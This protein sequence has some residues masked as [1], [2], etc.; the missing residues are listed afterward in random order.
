MPNWIKNTIAIT[1]SVMIVLGVGAFLFY[2]L[3]SKSLPEYEGVKILGGLS[4]RVSIYT[5][6]YAIP[7]I[8]AETE[9]DAAYALGYLHARDRLFQMD[10]A[11]RAGEGRL[12]EIFGS[13][14]VIFDK[15]FKTVGID[16]TVSRDMDKINPLSRRM[17]EAYSN[18]VNAYIKESKGKLPIEFDALQYEPYPWK[19]EHSLIIGKL[20][21]WELNISWWTDVTFTHLVQKLGEDKVKEILPD[22]PENAPTII[23]SGIKAS[24]EVSTGF[25]ETDR[26][27]RNF[28]GFNGTHIGSNNWVVNGA[29]SAS[30][31]P[32]IA[33][34][35]HLAL[36]APGRW[37]AAVIR[38][39]DWKAEGVTL[40]GLPGIVIG[41]NE[42]ISWVLT[43]VMADDADFYIEHLD[44]SGKKYQFNN[45]WQNIKYSRYTIAVK[46]SEK[47][48]L[49]VKETHRG[50]II[51]DIHPYAAL[52]PDK[53]QKKAVL[54]MRWT[55]NEF[56]DELFAIL[57]INK[58]RNW[59]EFR[60]GVSHFYVPGQNFVYADKGGNIGYI[61]AARLPIRS[62]VNSTFI[63]DGATDL[64]DWKGYVPF[65]E[66]PMLYNPPENYIASANNKTVKN[67]NYHISNLWEPPSRITRITELLESKNRHS[68]N[69]FMRYQMDF[70]SPY[71][72]EM[73]PFIITAFNDVKVKDRTLDG[74]LNLLKVWDYDMGEYSQVPAI[75]EVFFQFLMR[76]TFEDE[77]GSGLYN[78]YVFVANVPYRSI[79]KMLKENN[80]TWFD[81]KNTKNIETRDDILRK[82]L[83]DAIRYFESYFG[84]NVQDWQWGKLHT[85]TFKHMFHGRFS[86][87][88]KYID[89]GPYGIG[90]SGTS[91]FN[92]EYSF[93]NPYET[94]LGPSMRF[95][96]D[97][98]KPE[99]FY[100]IL[101]TGQSGNV[102]SDHYKDMTEMWLTGKYLRVPTEE[103]TIKNS[104]YKLMIL[105]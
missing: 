72:R 30:G 95:L 62:S 53:I 70:I 71:V 13:R 81:D 39:G 88:D 102:L 85:V 8:Y 48:E 89:I 82:S 18:G 58:A 11:R 65:E 76:N 47:V 31:K 57:S 34:D 100:L 28:I 46:D 21:A 73:T 44:S 83:I 84:S 75:F 15:M 25:V 36:Q 20:L 101:T 50:P 77:M 24:P 29:R 5:D 4:S 3:L 41:K 35:P 61:C 80:S 97:F 10:I 54:S 92:T 78:E 104:G 22:F 99:A 38:G 6:T 63:C 74:I 90:G 49:T 96:Y 23:P 19:P 2:R 32:I 68:V 9:E 37:Y 7:Y 86:V 103:N 51:S 64:Y 93:N 98:S 66:M 12:S 94:V 105:Q 69:D 55:G 59:E 16:R 60:S 52:Y 27:F 17:L 67:F 43:N 33:N 87:L 79:L 14:T 45:A 40:P 42:N 26:A 56:S 91:I 1:I